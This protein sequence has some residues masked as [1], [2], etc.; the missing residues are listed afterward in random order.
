[1]QIGAMI[2]NGPADWS[3]IQQTDGYADIPVSGTWDHNEPLSRPEV[4]ARIV[5]EDSSTV[6][7][8]WTRCHQEDDGR[9]WSIVLSG[10]PAGGLYRIET[11][12]SHDGN[13]FEWALRGDMIHHVGVGDVFVIAGQS[14]SSGFG[15]DPIYDPPE[16]GIHLLRNRGTWDIA[17][18]PLNESTGTV[19]EANREGSNGGHSP[20][21]SF[22]RHLKRELGYPVG[23]IQT[24]AGGSRLGE[25]NPDEEGALYRNLLEIVKSQGGHCRVSGIL[26]HQGCSDAAL[27]LGDDYLERFVRF[28]ANLRNDLGDSLLPVLTVQLNRLTERADETADRHWGQVREAQRQAPL[29]L[30]NVYI[31]PSI[32]CTLSDAIHNDSP[33]NLML[34][35][36]LA[37]V[38][39][40]EL[41]G[42]RA[43]YCHAPNIRQA[44]QTEDRRVKLTFDH[45]NTRLEM[46]DTVKHLFPFHLEDEAGAVA[47]DGFEHGNDG[48]LE[49]RLGREIAGAAR[50]HGCFEQNPSVFAPFDLDSH[51][52]MLCFYNVAVTKE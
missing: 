34:G 29:L 17:S 50:I 6:I 39:L 37:N 40:W 19:H 23:L 52:P 21:L 33:S 45:V 3:I 38:A 15:R 44:V 31:V 8:P 32:D 43:V 16:L 10:V 24:A 9:R 42:R 48:N 5:R 4:C 41:Y 25:W 36:R 51:L 13:P 14:N 47:V 12:L 27:G 7:V 1:M 28:I 30:N 2:E 26:W 46:Y 20:Y 49:L 22:A 35:E 18:H 11:C